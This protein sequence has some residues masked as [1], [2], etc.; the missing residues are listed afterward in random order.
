MGEKHAHASVHDAFS[1]I[2]SSGLVAHPLI[3]KLL[4]SY[5]L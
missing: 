5:F 4:S 2:R 1:S 3:H